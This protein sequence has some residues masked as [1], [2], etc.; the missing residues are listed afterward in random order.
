MT[1]SIRAAELL[2]RADLNAADARSRKVSRDA[3][4]V[5]QVRHVDHEKPTQLF[6]GFG[7]GTVGRRRF[8]FANPYGG[9][10]VDRMER[11]GGQELAEFL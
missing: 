3:D 9:C 4:G 11:G 8:P 10:S 6:F 1:T 7:K 5:I 2:H